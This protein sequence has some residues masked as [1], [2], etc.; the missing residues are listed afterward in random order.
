MTLY[1]FWAWWPAAEPALG[2]AEM[3]DARELAAIHGASFHRGWDAHEFETMLVDRAVLSHVIRR[4]PAAPVGGFVLS[5]LAADEAEILTVAVLPRLRGRGFAARLLD[6]HV[7]D[8]MRAGIATLFLEV[9][10]ENAPALKL[11][12]RQ[13]FTVIGRRKGY[14]KTASGTSDAVMMRKALPPI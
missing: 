7:K 5:R 1:D 12:Q 9:E 10:A 3:A 14:Y 4:R 2:R 6:T 13:G 8:L 11:Y